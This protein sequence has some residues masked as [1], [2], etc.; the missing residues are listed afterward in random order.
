VNV[1][2]RRTRS[3][4]TE[5][6]TLRAYEDDLTTGWVVDRDPYGH[7]F[8]VNT[9]DFTES[10]LSSRPVSL[11][12]IDDRDTPVT[13]IEGND[14]YYINDS[15]ETY[16]VY[17]TGAL[18]SPDLQQPIGVLEWN[19]GGAAQNSGG[20]WT[21]VSS[22]SAPGPKT[23]R[24]LPPTTPHPPRTVLPNDPTTI[25][26]GTCAGPN[27]IST[28][29]P[30]PTPT[31]FPT[32]TPPGGSNS[33]NAVFISQSVPSGMEAGQTYTVSVT[34]QNTGS[35]TWTNDANYRLGS[36]NPQDNTTWGF[37]R[38]FLPAVVAPGVQVTFTFNVIAPT[39]PSTYN[40]QWRMVQDAVE[41]FGD[42]TPNVL[43]SVSGSGCDPVAEDECYY[44]GGNWNPTTC[45]CHYCTKC[46]WYT[47]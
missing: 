36:Q 12:S 17:F 43:V 35:T 16:V 30:T 19:F 33:N 41:W 14:A 27:P 31:P 46:D 40:F 23:G 4:V 3:G 34:M 47:Y 1:F 45:T 38:V 18:L 8:R 2:E 11:V 26:W 44:N 28:P 20:S 21:F 13:V 42:Y 39:T 32:P 15:F 9:T 10:N 25:P 5:C 7:S 24:A 6:S 22:L 29:T 37:N